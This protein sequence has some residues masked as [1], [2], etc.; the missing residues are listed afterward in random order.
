MAGNEHVDAVAKKGDKV[1]ETHIREP[2]ILFN[3]I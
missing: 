2:T 3:Y 1:V